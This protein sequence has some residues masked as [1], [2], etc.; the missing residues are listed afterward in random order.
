MKL[1]LSMSLLAGLVTAHANATCMLNPASPVNNDNAFLLVEQPAINVSAPP[2]QANAIYHKGDQVSYQQT[3]YQARW[4]TQN[5]TPGPTWVSWQTLIQ[6]NQTWSPNSAYQQGDSVLYQGHIYL[7]EYW[8]QDQKP[9][10]SGAW[11]LN[12]GTE[13]LLNTQFVRSGYS[14]ARPPSD[15]DGY[16]WESNGLNALNMADEVTNEV[17]FDYVIIEHDETVTVRSFDARI[18]DQTCSGQDACNALLGGVFHEVEY[19]TGY[20]YTYQQ[21]HGTLEPT[22]VPT[23]PSPDSKASPPPANTNSGQRNKMAEQLAPSKSNTNNMPTVV[24][25]YCNQAHICRPIDL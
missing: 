23:P 5:E 4:W 6:M 21:S 15:F 25:K 2:W 7:A 18:Q 20:S 1:S 13:K 12:P 3:V 16:Y 22:P 9:V 10:Q 11:R 17:L 8:N 14:C 24:V 19:L